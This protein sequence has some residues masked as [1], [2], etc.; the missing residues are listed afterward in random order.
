MKSILAV[1]T[2]LLLAGVSCQSP[3][4]VNEDP[5]MQLEVGMTYA[6][7][8]N[9]LGEPDINIGYGELHAY[10][11]IR[12]GQWFVP[13]FEDDKVATVEFREEPFAAK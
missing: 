3:H 10:W 11:K 13:A 4:D 8:V 9:V 12:E 5:A 6:E 2:S 7:V 1:A